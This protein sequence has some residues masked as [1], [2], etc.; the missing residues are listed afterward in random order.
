M[1]FLSDIFGSD[2]RLPTEECVK[3]LRERQTQY[4]FPDKRLL[5]ILARE[6]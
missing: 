5:D 2:S 1:F 3:R 4:G 6:Q